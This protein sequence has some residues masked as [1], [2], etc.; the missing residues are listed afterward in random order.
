MFSL[1][2]VDLKVQW[3]FHVDVYMHSWN[4]MSEFRS[5]IRARD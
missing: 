5:E 4:L 2:S 1:G 3:D